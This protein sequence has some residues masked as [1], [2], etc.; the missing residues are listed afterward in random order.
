M[1]QRFPPGH[2]IF[3]WFDERLYLTPLMQWASKKTVPMHRHSFWYYMGGL[4]LIYIV[5]QFF[6][7]ILLMV[8]YVP[9]IKSAYSSIL[10]I[11]SQVDFGWFVRSLHSWGSNLLMIFLFL[12]LFSTLLMRAYRPPREL[13]WWS[14]LALLGI[15]MAFGFTGYLLPW[16]ELA[17]FA[18]KIGVD[19]ASKVPL[20]GSSLAGLIRGGE[21]LGGATLARFYT[22]H[23]VVLPL[24][25][26]GI[27]GFHLLL[28][29]LLGT[30][31]PP[32]YWK[33]PPE[34]RETE[35]FFPTF[36][37]KDFMGWL[38]VINLLALL[39]ALFPWGIGPEVKPF[40]PAPA[41]IKPEW[42]FLA[43]YQFLKI[44]PAHIGP[45]E[46]EVVGIVLTT[47]AVASLAVVPLLDRGQ[48][49]WA[50]KLAQLYGVALVVG[51]VVFTVWGYLS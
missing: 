9:E 14:G 46:G 5:L 45:F 30:S 51:F 26:L 7:G 23:V 21:T 43:P 33:Q 37:F 2:R 28:I 19:I 35:D 17:F 25:L 34:K 42:Y 3:Q 24:S 18:T 36:L 15:T 8:Y 11:N 6:T 50:A 27:M 39:V 49:V 41:G 40:A 16:D 20:I 48:S 10:R 38:L 47:L 44:L 4:V 32:F 13:T 1:I 29:Q 31:A 22:L 12:H